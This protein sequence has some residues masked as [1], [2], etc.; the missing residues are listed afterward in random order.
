MP[1]TAKKEARSPHLQRIRSSISDTIGAQARWVRRKSPQTRALPSHAVEQCL[2]AIFCY[3]A[4]PGRKRKIESIQLDMLARCLVDWIGKASK[5]DDPIDRLVP[6]FLSA[7]LKHPSQGILDHEF[8]YLSP[9]LEGYT[10]LKEKSDQGRFQWLHTHLPA[11]LDRL[12]RVS[13]CFLRHCP[14]DTN[15]PEEH[16]LR[17]WARERGAKALKFHILAHFHGTTP[18]TIKRYTYQ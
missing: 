7:A 16:I 14:M 3:Y 8:S 4:A 1:K 10:R 17:G 5:E 13:R 12:H 15:I 6:K 9:Q 2:E 18:R 11:L